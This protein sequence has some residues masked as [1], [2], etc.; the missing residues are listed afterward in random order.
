M[1]V[2]AFGDTHGVTDFSY[3]LSLA[4]E[5]DVLLCVGDVT[6]FGTAVE[7]VVAG[8][9]ALARAAGK[10]L[11]LTHGNH[12]QDLSGVISRVAPEIVYVHERVHVH[13]DELVIY[14]YGGGGFRTRDSVVEGFLRQAHR[15]HASVQGVHLWLFHGPPHDAGVDVV[16]G[17]GPTGC[18]SKRL[19]LEELV[20][21]VVVAGHIH[22]Q[23]GLVQ[24][25]GSTLVVNPGPDGVLLELGYPNTNSTSS[26]SS[27][28]SR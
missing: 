26:S 2:L 27:G 8:L 13:G 28:E 9:A 15:E 24:E 25:V 21:D 20:P 5:A 17:L 14:G 6:R 3:L 10:P 12:E 19:L 4:Q 1:K 7:E 11:V 18:K 23:F 22:E 16:P